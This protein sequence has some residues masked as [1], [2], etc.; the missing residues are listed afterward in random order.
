[1]KLRP[2]VGVEKEP[3][4]IKNKKTAFVV[5]KPPMKRVIPQNVNV[6]DI[7]LFKMR[8]F[9]AWPALVIGIN[10]KVVE[11]EFFGDH[12]TQKS[13]KKENIL[14]FKDS[15]DLILFNL[16]QRKCQLYRK[17]I[18]EA[19]VLLDVPEM[20]SILNQIR[21]FCYEEVLFFKINIILIQKFMLNIVFE[22][23]SE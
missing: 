16:R 22:K 14:S 12:T 10:N 20:S 19:E 8:G 9:F 7:V 21:I 2:R 18:R 13:S 4:H 11:V 5:R 17:A 3:N 1:M 15:L 23:Y 6:N